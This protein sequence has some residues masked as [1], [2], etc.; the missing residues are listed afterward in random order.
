MRWRHIQAGGITI[1]DWVY[2][3]KHRQPAE[4]A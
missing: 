3:G 4:L 1:G 2:E